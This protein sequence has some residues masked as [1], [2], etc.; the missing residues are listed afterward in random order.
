MPVLVERRG[1]L[2]AD[3]P[4]LTH[5]GE[6]DAAAAVVQQLDRAIEPIVETGNER[7]DR[8]GFG[9]EHLAR[10]RAVSH[11]SYLGSRAAR[12]GSRPRVA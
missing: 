5:A 7:E 8:R 11:A 12:I 1:N 6:D 4:R 10:Q 9:L 2:P 3:D